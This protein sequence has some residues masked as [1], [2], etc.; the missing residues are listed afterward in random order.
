MG[1]RRIKIKITPNKSFC[2]FFRANI[3]MA[4]GEYNFPFNLSV[5]SFTRKI[6]SGVRRVV[7]LGISQVNSAFIQITT[8][9]FFAHRQNR[10]D[11][12]L[13][14]VRCFLISFRCFFSLLLLLLL[15]FYSH[16]LFGKVPLW[17]L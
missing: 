16:L 9:A 5:Y 3:S 14:A 6:I 4:R 10:I 7:F 11:D 1:C 13:S 2:L 8:T 12:N 17:N 15:L